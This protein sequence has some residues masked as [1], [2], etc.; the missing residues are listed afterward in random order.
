MPEFYAAE[1]EHQEWKRQVLNGEIVLGEIDTAP[2]R[3][4]LGPNAVQVVGPVA[5]E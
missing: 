2:F 4:R 3:E 5:A 1:P